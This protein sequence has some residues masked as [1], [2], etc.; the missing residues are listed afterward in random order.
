MTT[1]RYGALAAILA[2]TALVTMAPTAAVNAAGPN[3]ARV[4]NFML[5]DAGFEAHELYR[6]SDAP[7]I[8]LIT[9]QNGD[10][11]TQELAPAINAMAASYGAKGVEFRMLNSSLKDTQ[12][13]IAAE[14]AKV[15]YK[16]PVLMDANQLVG[17]SLGVT[18]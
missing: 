7:A 13:A 16:V 1:A 3:P 8:V 6:L 4:D 15:G 12:P 10:K 9:Q 18:R 17:E 2:S 5:V 11:V 14:V